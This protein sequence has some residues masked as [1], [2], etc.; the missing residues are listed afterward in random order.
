MSSHSVTQATEPPRLDEHP[1]VIRTRRL[2]DA[3]EAVADA[4]SDASASVYGLEPVA[5]ELLGSL[6]DAYLHKAEAAVARQMPLVANRALSNTI[7]YVIA[8]E[9]AQDGE[10][11]RMRPVLERVIVAAIR[12]HERQLQ[13]ALREN[14]R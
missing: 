7:D 5:P 14:V 4:L 12:E 10:A 2:L 11:H 13:H 3:V 6:R 1:S 8:V 9:Q